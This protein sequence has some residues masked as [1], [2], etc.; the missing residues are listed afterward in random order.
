MTWR[1]GDGLSRGA[2]LAIIGV[3]AL[4]VGTL[5]VAPMMIFASG[6]FSFESTVSE[7]LTSL[8]ETISTGH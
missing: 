1:S 7:T 2:V 6:S 4:L 3:V 5:L 8:V